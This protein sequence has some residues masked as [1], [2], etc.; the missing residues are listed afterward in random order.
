MRSV[1][2]HLGEVLLLGEPLPPQEVP[3]AVDPMV[4]LAEP[5]MAAL[6]VPPFDNSAMDGFA[7]RAR[8]VARAPVELAVVGDLP[9][10]RHPEG[11]LRAGQAMRIMTGAPLPAGADAV[12][13]VE[14]TDQPP[15]DAPLPA[16]VR[17]RTCVDPGRHVRRAGEDVRAGDTVLP[18]GAAATPAAVAA[19]V[20]VGAAAW[21][22]RRRPRVAVISTGSELVGPGEP[23]GPGR[24]PDSNLPLLAGLVAQHGGEVV[25]RQRVADD[26]DAFLAAVAR[27]AACD[28]VLTTGGV[29]VGAFE[30]VRQ[31]S[32]PAVEFVSV[33]MQPGKPQGL[34]R[35]RIDGRDVPLL[36]L[37]GNPVSVFVSAWLFVR[38]LLA[39][40]GGRPTALATRRVT[41]AEGWR[42]PAGRA[43][44]VP[45][46]LTVDG[47]VR[48]H[49]G[50]S[51]SHAIASLH[52]ADAVAVVPAEW[53]QVRPGDELEVFDV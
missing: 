22:V 12:V 29:S 31:A 27:C 53:D 17:V 42:S 24:I 25:Q 18:A 48:A 6:A 1:A 20:S 26:P 33:A 3:V 4:S 40:M 7:V 35:L 44:Y 2:E 36:A 47:V 43:Q 19:A 39:T 45:A 32:G 16:R 9:A 49:P 51:R 15:G 21:R 41:A 30:V 10:G 13:P 46:R 11:V 23:V 52:R 37:P 38:P 8:D 14:D 5:V 50:G 28:L 34:G